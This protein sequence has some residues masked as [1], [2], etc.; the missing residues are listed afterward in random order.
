MAFQTTLVATSREGQ[1]TPQPTSLTTKSTLLSK[2]GLTKA[3][4]LCQSSHPAEVFAWSLL[5]WT[6]F[7]L[8]VLGARLTERA[9]FINLLSFF[10]RGSSAGKM[11][12]VAARIAYSQQASHGIVAAT[13]TKA[14]AKSST[15]RG[16]N[17]TPQKN[18]ALCAGVGCVGG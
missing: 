15:L 14:Y 12:L 7:L 1:H 17:R 4:W 6:N 11:S 16:Q 9:L 3:M 2:V 13:P 5:D 18:S 10:E 8:G